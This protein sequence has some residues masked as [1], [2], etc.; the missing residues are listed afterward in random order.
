MT[1]EKLLNALNDIDEASI[2]DAHEEKQSAHRR[3]SRRIAAVFA[4]VIVLVA[5]T[6]TAFA[7]EEI[8]G[9]FRAYFPQK[10]EN[11]LTPGQVEY[12]RENEQIIAEELEHNGYTIELKS[13]LS[14]VDTTYIIFR[15]TAPEDVDITSLGYKLSI[16]IEVSAEYGRAPASSTYRIIDDHDGL[17][18]TLDILHTLEAKYYYTVPEW[19]V[20]IDALYTTHYDEASRTHQETI[21]AEGPWDFTISMADADTQEMELLTEPVQ[22]L[23]AVPVEGEDRYD[24]EYVTIT[25]FVLR[26]L[27]ATISFDQN[28]WSNPMFVGTIPW[29]AIE[30]SI[31]AVMK[32]GSCV[33]FTNGITQADWEFKL[34]AESPIALEEVDYIF[35]A[36]GTKLMAP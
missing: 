2:R 6:V 29:T 25:S 19:Y 9:W 16:N 36:D 11:D 30:F 21:L 13:V 24:L 23:A 5:I 32:D 27:D 10:T 34:L 7:S 31:Y 22:T 35:L 20:H 8:V 1:P 33:R 3:G 15:I 4:A 14:S 28:I 12:I 17:D 26:P 18:H